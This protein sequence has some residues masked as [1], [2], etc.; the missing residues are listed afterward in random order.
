MIPTQDNTKIPL[1][2]IADIRTLTGP[3]FVYRDNN[4]RY[5]PVKFS[6]RGRD[7][8]SAIAEAQA[9]VNEAV[10]LPHGYKMSWN[11]EF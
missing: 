1:K 5:I 7:L 3:A 10:Q 8:G 9:K 4:A 6:V 2:E 11:G